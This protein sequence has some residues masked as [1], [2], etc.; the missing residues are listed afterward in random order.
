[1]LV[2]VLI[3]RKKPLGDIKSTVG[4]ECTDL[5]VDDTTVQIWDFAGQLEYTVTHQYFLSAKV[6]L[7][8]I[9]FS[10][11]ILFVLYNSSVH[12]FPHLFVLL[13]LLFV[14]IFIY[15]LVCLECF[16]CFEKGYFLVSFVCLFSFVF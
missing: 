4:I 3:P 7:L 1:M 8:F 12:F 6:K 11:Y 15:L 10:S 16:G 2:Y 13:V 14:L 5:S 9:Y